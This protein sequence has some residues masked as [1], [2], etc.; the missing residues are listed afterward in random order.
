MRHQTVALLERTKQ[1]L[2]GAKWNLIVMAACC[3]ALAVYNFVV[4]ATGVLGIATSGLAGV[5]AALPWFGIFGGALAIVGSFV[6]RS[7]WVLSWTEV[8]LDLIM[9]VLGFWYLFFP[10]ALGDY[11]T[12]LTC[13]GL[14]IAFYLVC[15]SMEQDRTGAGLWP[16]CLVVAA[17]VGILA[18][19]LIM[20]F[21][22]AV[23][24][25]GV[26]SLMLFIAGWGFVYGAVALQNVRVGI[27]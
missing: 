12:V 14:F 23:G 21:A 3:F 19:A 13:V 7:V 6:S 24:A 9:F 17:V 15:V 1:H 4:P 5:I 2:L 10:S 27:A 20:N 11:A 26:V 25:Q 16:V 22:G 8:V 18:F